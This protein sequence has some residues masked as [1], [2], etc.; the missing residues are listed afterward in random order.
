[1]PLENKKIEPLKLKYLC[2][3]IGNVLWKLAWQE[4]FEKLFGRPFAPFAA[5][6]AAFSQSSAHW[7]YEMGISDDT[8]FFELL[9]QHFTQ[10][11]LRPTSQ[12]VRQFWQDGLGAPYP[13]VNETLQLLARHFRLVALSNTNP[14]H[15]QIFSRQQEF[16]DF[17]KIFASHQL[18][19]RKPDP[20]IY[21]H[22]TSALAVRPE[23][24]LFMDDLLENIE[25]AHALGWQTWHC[26]DSQKLFQQL[27]RLLKIS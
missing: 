3:D 16:A 11:E 18:K 27:P 14:F 9:K 23:N 22:V 24:I 6:F 19:L 12:Q 13:W 26:T 21:Q 20:Q 10:H 8:Q 2:F 5:P 25:S 1:M 15:F 7:D 17:L 4:S